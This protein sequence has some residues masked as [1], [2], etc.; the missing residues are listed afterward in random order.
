MTTQTPSQSGGSQG[1]AMPD[2]PDSIAHDP[3]GYHRCP[4]A[5]CRARGHSTLAF[6]FQHWMKIPRYL[7]DA[8]WQSYRDG[9]A[10]TASHIQLIDEAKR[11]IGHKYAGLPEHDQRGWEPK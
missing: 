2:P 11:P 1:P 5:E 7:R 8:I 10:G 4:A 6:C 3:D 9:R